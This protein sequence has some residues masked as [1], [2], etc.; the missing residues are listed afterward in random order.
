MNLMKEKR[1]EDMGVQN[2]ERIKRQVGIYEM[3]LNEEIVEETKCYE[4][5]HVT[6]CDHKM[7]IRCVNYWFGTSTE[8]G[9]LSCTNRF[10]RFGQQKNSP[11]FKCVNFNRKTE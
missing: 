7:E 2:R 3:Q 4:C 5:V 8:S 1:K 9:C 10:G 11:C 6:V